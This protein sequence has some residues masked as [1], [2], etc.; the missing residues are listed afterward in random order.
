[1]SD[2][3]FHI[4]LAKMLN[5]IIH[6]IAHPLL[7]NFVCIRTTS[8]NHLC[9]F[10]FWNNHIVDKCQQHRDKRLVEKLFARLAGVEYL[11][12]KLK[13]GC[14]M[15]SNHLQHELK[16]LFKDRVLSTRQLRQ[17]H[18]TKVTTLMDMPE[19]KIR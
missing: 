14:A 11:K 19:A 1:M 18:L 7:L 8:K 3:A 15:N 16:I 5:D 17:S 12:D 2:K 10:D 13:S 9:H 6:L 4:L